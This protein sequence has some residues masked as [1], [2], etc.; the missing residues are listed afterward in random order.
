MNRSTVLPTLIDALSAEHRELLPQ[1]AGVSETAASAPA[2]LRAAFG[3]IAPLLGLPLDEHVANEDRELFPA[4]VS[5]GGDAGIL[6]FFTEEHREILALR[7]RLVAAL[8]SEDT[9][10][11]RSLAEQ[12]AK[13]LSSHIEREEQVLFPMMRDLL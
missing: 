6:W 1:L 7:N 8:E 9:G 3:R 11:I 5:A 4:Y 12:L 13:L 2:T 10:E